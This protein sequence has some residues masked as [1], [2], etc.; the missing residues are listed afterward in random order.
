MKCRDAKTELALFVGQ[1]HSD[2]QRWEEVRRH[3][4]ACVGCRVHFQR[5]K[6]SLAVLESSEPESTYDRRGSLWPE[7]RKRL[8]A[9]PVPRVAGLQTWMPVTSVVVACLLLVAVVIHEP[10]P[11]DRPHSTISRGAVVWPAGGVNTAPRQQ[12]DDENADKNTV[13]TILTDM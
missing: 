10:A 7:L 13:K 12:M 1:D 8:D 2:T 9:Q 6:Q 4:S 3:V 11:S 5:L